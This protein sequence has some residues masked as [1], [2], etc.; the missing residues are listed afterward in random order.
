[1]QYN[2]LRQSHSVS[3]FERDRRDRAPILEQRERQIKENFEETTF[4]EVGR[5]CQTR[6][7]EKRR[8]AAGAYLLPV[9]GQRQ[10][11]LE[12]DR[13]TVLQKRVPSASHFET[14]C[15]SPRPR[16]LCSRAALRIGQT[17]W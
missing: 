14:R 1:M 8:R 10:K 2:K 7:E 9:A 6:P 17:R 4:G 16:A 15:D 3:V 11:Y 12:D 13:I 5:G